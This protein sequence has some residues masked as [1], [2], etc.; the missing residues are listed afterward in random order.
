MSNNPTNVFVWLLTKIF[1]FSDNDLNIQQHLVF[2]SIVTMGLVQ[3]FAYGIARDP[4]V[5][6]EDS[7]MN[8]H[9]Y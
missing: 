3:P 8:C 6:V 9:G 2:L 4:N 1:R 5:L 7:V